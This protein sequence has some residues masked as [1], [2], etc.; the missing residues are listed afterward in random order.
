[1][2]LG[3]APPARA[4]VA[5]VA[6]AASGASTRA[7][8]VL[9]AVPGGLGW[10][11]AITDPH[12]GH[13]FVDADGT[14]SMIDTPTG[15]VIRGVPVGLGYGT[16]A[17]DQSR[18]RLLVLSSGR[19]PIRVVA[20]TLAT[21]DTRSDTLLR[22]VTLPGG[23][24]GQLFLDGRAGCALA[25]SELG[26]PGPHYRIAITTVAISTGARVRTLTLAV[27]GPPVSGLVDDV[28]GRL[29]LVTS[30]LNTL[31]QPRPEATVV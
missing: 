26:T 19:G 24:G 4:G 29:V 18:P 10:G 2:A 25:W 11:T 23:A 21:I 30:P 17:V 16:L 1:V 27:A 20:P 14:V 9:H 5:A 3:V 22:S 12:T 31:S 8:L 15:I 28:H 6:R 13:T 7:P